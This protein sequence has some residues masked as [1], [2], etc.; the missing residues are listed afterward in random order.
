MVYMLPFDYGL[1]ES[2]PTPPPHPTLKK[3]F[4]MKR[5]ILLRICSKCLCPLLHHHLIT[6][7]YCMVIY[8]HLCYVLHLSG[9]HC[10]FCDCDHP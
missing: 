8:H 7:G 4:E 10:Q 2:L 6:H 3:Q 5:F 1:K 9:S